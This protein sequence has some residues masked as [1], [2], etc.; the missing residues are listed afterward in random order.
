MFGYEMSLPEWILTLPWELVTA[1]GSVGFVLA[2]CLAWVYRAQMKQGEKAIRQLE[3]GIWKEKI[4]V[5]PKELANLH[6]SN[7]ELE[8][9][10][11]DLQAEVKDLTCAF[12]YL[13][14]VNLKQHQELTKRIFPQQL[15]VTVPPG[16]KDSL[17]YR[18]HKLKEKAIQLA[19]HAFCLKNGIP[20]T[21]PVPENFTQQ[22]AEEIRLMD[23]CEFCGTY[24]PKGECMKMHAEVCHELPPSF[25]GWVPVSRGNETYICYG[26]G[27]SGGKGLDNGLHSK[28]L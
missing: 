2:S 17:I 22:E 23:T 28:S 5:E 20:W 4:A 9:K 3:A 16:H 15:M 1:A 24:R 8:D 7:S 11:N 10:N 12:E 13:K 6:F 27:G 26:A 14:S 19:K 18:S 21:D 25:Q